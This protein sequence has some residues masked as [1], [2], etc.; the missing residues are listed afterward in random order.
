MTSITPFEP[1]CKRY[2]GLRLRSAFSR[3][4]IEIENLATLIISQAPGLAKLLQDNPFL[5]D[6]TYR[7]LTESLFWCKGISEG[8]VVLCHRGAAGALC[9]AAFIRD[10][11]FGGSAELNFFALQD[12]AYSCFEEVLAYMFRPLMGGLGCLNV[13]MRIHPQNEQARDLATQFSFASKTVLIADACYHGDPSNMLLVELLNPTVFSAGEEIS[14]ASVNRSVPVSP[15]QPEQLHD[16][17]GGAGAD[18][19]YGDDSGEPDWD[20]DELLRHELLGHTGIPATARGTDVDGSMGQPVGR[21]GASVP[22][23]P[24]DDSPGPGGEPD[25]TGEPATSGIR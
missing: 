22:D 8:E 9:G 2:S 15:V 17:P 7:N 23:S 12:M 1:H 16:G 21:D 25:V 24:G 5:V 19:A 14:N 13:R 18:Q 11:H 4:N 20:A 3:H 6:D 10:V